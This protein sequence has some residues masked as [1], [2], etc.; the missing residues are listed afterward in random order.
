L[1]LAAFGLLCLLAFGVR[2][3]LK[4]LSWLETK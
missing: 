4:T 2:L 1:G 3:I